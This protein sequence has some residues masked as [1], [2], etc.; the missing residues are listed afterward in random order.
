M[1]SLNRNSSSDLST[2]PNGS[3]FFGFGFGYLF[4]WKSNI[5][6]AFRYIVRKKERPEVFNLIY[7]HFEIWSTFVLYTTHRWVI[8]CKIVTYLFPIFCFV[9]FDWI[10]VGSGFWTKKRNIFFPFFPFACVHTH[11]EVR[12][13]NN[14]HFDWRVNHLLWF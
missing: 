3:I 13:R 11:P 8:V 10:F 9:L 2:V 7:F 5:C 4:I 14:E 1:I 12:S 6:T